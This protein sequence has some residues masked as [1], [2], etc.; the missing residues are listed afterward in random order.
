MGHQEG[1]GQARRCAHHGGDPIQ[2]GIP[3][4]DMEFNSESMTTSASN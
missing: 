2:L 4:F 1:T 3:E